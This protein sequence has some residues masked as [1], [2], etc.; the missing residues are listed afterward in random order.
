MTIKKVWNWAVN[1]FQSKFEL[2]KQKEVNIKFAVCHL[3]FCLSMINAHHWNGNDQYITIQLTYP[4]VRNWIQTSFWNRKRNNQSFEQDSLCLFLDAFQHDSWIFE[5]FEKYIC[6][7]LAIFH[8]IKRDLIV[9]TWTMIKSH[10][11]WK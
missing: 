8:C 7:P 11:R 6:P 2:F 10:E 3:V 1:Q 5:I 9:R 4:E